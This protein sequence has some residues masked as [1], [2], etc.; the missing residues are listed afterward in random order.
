MAVLS[1]K[2]LTLCGLNKDRKKVLELIQRL[3]VVE[4]RKAKKD[5]KIFKRKDVS[6]QKATFEK[7]ANVIEQ[8]L[9][10]MEKVVDDKRSFF[11]K[12]D[13]RIHIKTSEFE[14]ATKE[15]SK[16]YDKANDIVNLQKESIELTNNIPRLELQIEALKP[17]LSF[18]LPLNFEGTANTK[19]FIGQIKAPMNELELYDA[20]ASYDKGLE[21]VNI[22]VI[23]SSNELTCLCVVCSNDIAVK[24]Q[25][26]LVG[27]EFVRAPYTG[28]NP[29]QEVER[30]KDEISEANNRIEAIND[31]LKSYAG[32]IN[33]MRLVHDFYAMRAG[34]YDIL[35]SIVQSD[36]VFVIR[37]YIA[38]PYIE[39]FKKAI[40]PYD[41]VCEFEDISEKDD[42]PTMLKNN[43]FASPLESVVESYS[44]PGREEFDPT[45]LTALFYYML[46]GLMYSDAAY[47]LILVIGTALVLAKCKHIEPEFRK[48][49]KLFQYCGIATTFWGFMFG[50]FFGDAV[51]VI[52]A[53][54]FN[55]PDIKLPA[56]W[57][58]P[59][60]EPMRMLVFSFA[61][62]LAHL[63][64]GLLAQMY[65]NI[66]N[67]RVKDAIYDDVSWL[68]FV[69]GCVVLLLSTPMITGMLGL[70]FTLSATAKTVGTAL[71][72][73]G[74]LTVLATAGR[75]SKAFGKRFLKGLYGVYGITGY[76][77]D[78]LSY[79]RLLALGLATGVIASVFNKIGSMFGKSI[80]GVILFII[81]FIIGHVL[82]LLIN[83]LGAYVHANRL[84]YVEFYGKF[85]NGGGRR[86][87][88]FAEN[89]KYYRVE[90]D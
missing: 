84:Q 10:I 22:D 58:V 52:A 81:V 3:G 86:F 75:E 35:S 72:L 6:S 43:G 76:L 9:S 28:T 67:G 83:V 21:A 55:R 32:S 51:D 20:I 49:I 59:V 47:G 63:M 62:G 16:I 40:E 41:L 33:N 37:G 61:I 13:G 90:E 26:A 4:V 44:L 71:S 87:E 78:V 68:F 8:A 12:M 24:V 14:S 5:G 64:L 17:W 89:T 7:S 38:E 18:D 80:I 54:F 48:T 82:N 85:Y 30:L 88:P 39:N 56:L 69:G 19:A 60:N 34:K 77:S 29:H 23:S 79:S 31:E 1:T 15:H 2:R 25:E 42:E 65:S 46:F 11:E 74:M 70:S 50:S 73:I 36:H 45:F 53:T 57:F 66:K 27:L